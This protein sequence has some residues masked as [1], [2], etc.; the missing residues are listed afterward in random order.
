M[1]SDETWKQLGEHFD[2]RQR[3]DLVTVGG[4]LMLSMAFNT[5]GVVPE[6]ER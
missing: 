1:L 4:Y 3:M 5:F 2:D 6:S